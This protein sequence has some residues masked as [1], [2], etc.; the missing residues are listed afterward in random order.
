L[1][2]KGNSGETHAYQFLSSL[3]ML[4]E[5]IREL[6]KTGQGTLVMEN[7]QFAIDAINVDVISV[8]ADTVV[9]RPTAIEFRN[10]AD[11]RSVMGVA[12][13][14][15]KV[16]EVW[17]AADTATT[18]LAEL[19]RQHRAIVLNTPQHHS[20]LNAAAA[21]IQRAVGT[22]GDYIGPVADALGTTLP[23]T[24]STDEPVIAAL[25]LPEE[26]PTPL[27]VVKRRNVRIW[28][29]QLVRG[30]EAGRFRHDVRDAYG[31]RCAFSGVRL[32]KLSI[33]YTPGVDAA[34]ILP[35]SRYEMNH[36]SNGICLSKLFHWA[37]DN[38][39]VRLDFLPLTGRYELSIPEVARDAAHHGG[40]DLDPLLPHIGVLPAERFP[41]RAAFRP[42]KEFLEQ[43]NAELF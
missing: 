23:E 41:A 40:M 29:M 10:A 19:V 38:G 31:S 37:F 8:T 17:R 20:E 13:R 43:L 39:I 34:H 3:L 32:P 5:P 30:P 22:S 6:S 28:R 4:P 42:K 26:D 7:E 9:L 16:L 24:E 33:T 15:A 27:I 11:N 14:M 36:V 25:P 18:Q 2:N 12:D 35:W 1:E 21:A